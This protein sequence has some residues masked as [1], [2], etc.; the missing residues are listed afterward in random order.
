MISGP[1]GY[2]GSSKFFSYGS[3]DSESEDETSLEIGD[4]A[5]GVPPTQDS[6]EEG[7]TTPVIGTVNANALQDTTPQVVRD[8]E[9]AIIDGRYNN[10][11]Y[12]LTPGSK[13][14]LDEAGLALN[15]DDLTS[16]KRQS[17]GRRLVHTVTR[18]VIAPQIVGGSPL[19]STDI[20]RQAV[21]IV[22]KSDY[23]SQMLMGPLSASRPRSKQDSLPNVMNS[24]SSSL[25]YPLLD[26]DHLSSPTEGY[27]WVRNMS[28]INFITGPIIN[29]DTGAFVGVFNGNGRVKFSSFFPIGR[30]ADLTEL[31]NTLHSGTR[32]ASA[33]NRHLIQDGRLICEVYKRSGVLIRSAFPIFHYMDLSDASVRFK[34]IPGLDTMTTDG[35]VAFDNMSADD[36]LS[37]IRKMIFSHMRQVFDDEPSPL[38]FITI[39]RRYIFDLA[40][41]YA[42]TFG[43][44]SGIYVVI[45]R[46]QLEGICTNEGEFPLEDI[47]FSLDITF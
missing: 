19:S 3:S 29:P 14:L 40:P 33:G 32:I 28:E 8:L 34:L 24:P 39:D 36:V 10:T 12:T 47:L 20:E 21:Q 26:V 42:K 1:S 46:T 6:D 31:K 22:A 4:S 15:Q 16:P 44:N 23:L 27:H 30:F 11:E 38:R 25:K 43:V 9:S 17:I 35:D 5:T 18:E 45:N 2:S 41:Y 13:R 7:R 37:L